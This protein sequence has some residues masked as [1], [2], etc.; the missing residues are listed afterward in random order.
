M[1]KYDSSGVLMNAE[2]VRLQSL[3]FAL[4]VVNLIVLG[5]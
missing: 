3:T 1:V 4:N 2:K 5:K